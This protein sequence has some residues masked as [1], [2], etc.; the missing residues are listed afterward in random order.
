M[1]TLGLFLLLTV[2]ATCLAGKHVF[3]IKDNSLYINS[4]EFKMI[5]LR[6][7][8]AL[9]TDETT[10]DLIRHLDIYKSYGVNTVSVY[11]MG[12]RFGDVKGYRPDASLDP[13]YTNRMGRIIEAADER[14]MI[15]IVGCLY[16]STSKAREELEHWTQVE[17][18]LAVA[19]TVSWLVQNDYMNVLLDPDNEGMAVRENKWQIESL[20]DAAH[21]VDRMIMV[22]NN[23]H[24]SAEH[25]DINIHFGP[26]EENK[27]WL[28]SEATPEGT[29][30]FSYWGEFSK[31]THLSDQSYYNYSRVGRYTS[32]M[33][34][35][36]LERTLNE[37]KA[38]NGHMLASTWLQCGPEEGIDGPFCEPGGR[39]EMGSSEYEKAP[40][41]INIDKLHPDAGILWW[42][43]FIKKNY[44][45]WEV[46]P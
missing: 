10:D 6:C 38:Y 9:I 42:L 17:A 36:Q 35:N 8:N 37:I 23:T 16:W 2:S 7:S 22:A 40:W 19:N 13:L 25:S 24:Q 29:G 12:S 31:A 28:D 27:P 14:G 34:K 46:I 32:E 33:K 30:P 39:S 4:Q 44:G 45:P 15:V 18:R 5:G 1:K 21:D 11:F 20:I 3:S 41:N 43:E 26:K